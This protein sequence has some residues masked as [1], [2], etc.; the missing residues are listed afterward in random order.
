MSLRRIVLDALSLGEPLAGLLLD[1]L[2]DK[3][4]DELL[5]L[6]E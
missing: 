4:L 3:L 5:L 1:E 6:E 2:L